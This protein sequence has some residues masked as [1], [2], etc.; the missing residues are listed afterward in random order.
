MSFLA[1]AWQRG[2]HEEETR[3]RAAMAEEKRAEM[4]RDLQRWK[5]LQDKVCRAQGAEWPGRPRPWPQG[6]AGA[7]GVCCR[8]GP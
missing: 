2:G 3:E 1:Q 6:A 8:A 4:K 5:E 7:S